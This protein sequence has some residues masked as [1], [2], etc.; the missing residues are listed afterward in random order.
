MVNGAHFWTPVATP[1]AFHANFRIEAD[2]L[3]RLE[4]SLSKAELVGSDLAKRLV[5]ALK[6]ENLSKPEQLLQVITSHVEASV[7]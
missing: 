5:E 6:A 2:V 3:D 4:S 7:K 1:Q